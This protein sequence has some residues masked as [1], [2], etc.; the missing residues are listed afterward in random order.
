MNAPTVVP[1]QLVPTHAPRGVGRLEG[2]RNFPAAARIAL[3]DAQLRSNLRNATATIRAKRAPDSVLISVGANDAHFGDVVRHCVATANC[4]AKPFD[5]DH[6]GGGLDA[7]AREA[8]A[9]A[10]LAGRYDRLAVALR[11]ARIDPRNVV[12]SEYFDPTRNVNA[13]TCPLGILGGTVTTEPSIGP[14]LASTAWPTVSNTG[15][16]WTSRPLRP[17][18]TPPTTLDP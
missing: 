14:P 16:P 10:A 6:E 18:V 13:K 12:L 15:T 4:P 5:P 17:G 2:E 8:Q 3:A 1:V 9:L 7:D 11:S